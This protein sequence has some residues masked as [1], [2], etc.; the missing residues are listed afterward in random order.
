GAKAC[1]QCGRFFASVRCPACG[2]SGE[3]RAFAKGCPAC[4]YSAPQQA[5][6]PHREP[7]VPA[8]PLPLW[9]YLFSIVALLAVFAVLYF[10][11]M[12]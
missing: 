2:Y 11:I 7:K 10:G 5:A 8:G 9:V 1:P 6:V 3:D 12:K 4:G